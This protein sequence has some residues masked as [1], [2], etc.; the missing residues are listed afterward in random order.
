MKEM[1]ERAGLSG[2]LGSAVLG[3]LVPTTL[4]AAPAPHCRHG[5][6]VPFPALAEPEWCDGGSGRAAKH[7]DPQLL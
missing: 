1:C 6:P 7:E 2:R 4:V 3:V 5:P